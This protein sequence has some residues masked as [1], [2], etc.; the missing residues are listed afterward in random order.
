MGRM[1]LTYGDLVS[2]DGWLG[3]VRINSVKLLAL[4]LLLIAGWV[5]L[6]AVTT[7]GDPGDIGGG[8]LLLP[9]Y[10]CAGAGAF[11][12]FKDVWTSWFTRR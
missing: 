1:Q 5:L 12:V 6:A 8:L 10:F 4:G 11:L 3:P 7:I 2:E 9:G